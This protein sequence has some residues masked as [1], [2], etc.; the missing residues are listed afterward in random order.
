ME[1][2]GVILLNAMWKSIAVT[3]TSASSSTP[4]V[5]RTQNKT[6]QGLNKNFF[7]RNNIF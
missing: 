2:E 5:L 3:T 4:Y 1:I 7:Q 6:V